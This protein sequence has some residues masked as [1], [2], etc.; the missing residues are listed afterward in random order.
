MR[1]FLNGAILASTL[2]SANALVGTAHAAEKGTIEEATAMVKKAADY[3]KVN[4]NDKAFTEIS[5]PKGQFIDRDLYVFV[6]DTSGKSVAHGGN[7]QM[8]GQDLS[9]LKDA[10]GKPITKGLLAAASN[11]SGTYSYK[12]LNPVSKAIEP[13]TT[14]VQKVGDYVVGAG[15]YTK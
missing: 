3:M 12:Y 8:I 9:D 10:E 4:G 11:G 15:A 1:K 5:N 2:L 14:Y 13:K 6:T 7:P